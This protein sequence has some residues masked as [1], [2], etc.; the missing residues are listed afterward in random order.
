MSL[1]VFCSA[2]AAD[3]LH[4]A[5]VVLGSSKK[6]R[7]DWPQTGTDR[8]NIRREGERK[9]CGTGKLHLYCIGIFVFAT[10]GEKKI[11]DKYTG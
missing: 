10:D 7:G 11:P 1:G 6:G 8:G 3:E 4:E 5:A 2:L 9:I